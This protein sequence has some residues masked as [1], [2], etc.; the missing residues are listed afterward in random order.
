M[1]MKLAW[2][3]V[4]IAPFKVCVQRENLNGFPS[5]PRG[6]GATYLSV[7]PTPREKLKHSPPASLLLWACIGRC[8]Y[9]TVVVVAIYIL[10]M[11]CSLLPPQWGGIIK[12]LYWGGG[13]QWFFLGEGHCITIWKKEHSWTISNPFADMQTVKSLIYQNTFV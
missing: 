9:S 11:E 1:K 12:S 4:I 8:T 3:L 2:Q 7:I 5:S 6:F 10:S 13:K